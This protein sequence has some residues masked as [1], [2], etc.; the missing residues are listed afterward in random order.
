MRREDAISNS[1]KV[2]VMLSTI[3]VRVT[4]IKRTELVVFMLILDVIFDRTA[5]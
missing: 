2:V 4:P 3:G 1:G 5:K